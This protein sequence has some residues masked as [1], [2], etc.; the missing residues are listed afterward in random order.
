MVSRR[1]S[2]L[3]FSCLLLLTQFWSGRNILGQVQA[4]SVQH[5]T[6]RTTRNRGPCFMVDISFQV[7][8]KSD[9]PQKQFDANGLEF[10]E[11]Q[12]V[13]VSKEGLKAFQVPAKGKGSF[14]GTKFVADD[15]LPYLVV[16]VGLQGIV[17]RVFDSNAL[18]ANF[19]IRV[20]FETDDDADLSSPVP[21]VMHFEAREVEVVS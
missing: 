18:S 11:G 8:E 7:D 9:E 21:F 3:F 17:T 2:R 1:V 16:P 20:K 6:C 15:S 5:T 4:F 12:T 14:D 19:P 13:R 10:E